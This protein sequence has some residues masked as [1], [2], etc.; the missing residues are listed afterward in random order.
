MS[1]GRRVAETAMVVP[2][3]ESKTAIEQIDEIL[4]I[5]GLRAVQIACTDFSKELGYPFQY[6]HPEVWRAIDRLTEK[7]RAK[8]ITVVAN[9]GYDYTTA[10][11]ISGRV[12]R[13]YDHGV[14]VVLMQG[15]EFL[16][17]TFS[18]S[19]L[20]KIKTSN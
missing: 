18:K 19:L 15:A 17:E 20:E 1:Q 16:L 9:T 4:E 6:E 11:E 7:A 14:R 5:E 8:G 2:A 12:K 10:E 3:I 13:L